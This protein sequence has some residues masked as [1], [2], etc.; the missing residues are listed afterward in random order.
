MIIISD[1]AYKGEDTDAEFWSEFLK[2]EPEFLLDF[3][4]EMNEEQLKAIEVYKPVN[5]AM[6]E[7][8]KRFGESIG[9]STILKTGKVR[10]RQS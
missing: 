2:E 7:Q 6:R 4:E 3:E 10:G 9:I 8:N 5:S 1:G